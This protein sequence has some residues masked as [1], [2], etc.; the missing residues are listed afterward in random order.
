MSFSH[1]AGTNCRETQVKQKIDDLGF[2]HIQ[3]IKSRS[4]M[5][6]G[7]GSLL[8]LPDG[9]I[10]TSRWP[11]FSFRIRRNSAYFGVCRIPSTF[12]YTLCQRC[13]L[14]VFYFLVFCALPQKRTNLILIP[15][16]FIVGIH[17][18]Q[19]LH[20]TGFCIPDKS[21]S[22]NTHHTHSLAKII[23]LS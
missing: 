9:S 18:E 23:R 19:W 2:L 12:L 21:R 14:T 15:F 16:T 4:L 1:T 3:R 6:K 8:H 7:C 5:K 20:N 11:I 17:L 22:C 10:F 13:R